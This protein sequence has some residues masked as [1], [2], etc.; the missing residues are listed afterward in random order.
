MDKAPSSS[1]TLAFSL[2]IDVGREALELALRNGEEAVVFATVSSPLRRASS[3]ASFPTS[4]PREN[5]KV[6]EL[7]GAL[8]MLVNSPC[9]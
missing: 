4:I 9:W 2:G 5:A 8:S 1:S 3:K 7:L 6:L